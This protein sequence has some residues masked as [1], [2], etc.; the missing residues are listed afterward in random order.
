VAAWSRLEARA[1]LTADPALL[2]AA[3]RAE[4]EALAASA[5][6]QWDCA[7]TAVAGGGAA[8]ACRSA[9]ARHA[10]TPPAGLSALRVAV[11]SDLDSDPYADLRHELTRSAD[12]AAHAATTHALF[13]HGGAARPGCSATRC[14]CSARPR[15]A[16]A[17]RACT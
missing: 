10:A 5:A 16:A 4:A 6:T 3:A 1:Y 2:H 7:G 8:G 11:L 12:H 17:A 15:R 13:P 9:G 14:R